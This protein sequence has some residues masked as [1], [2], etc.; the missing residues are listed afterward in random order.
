MSKGYV[1]EL[2][3]QAYEKWEP[4]DNVMILAGTGKGKSHFIK[5]VLNRH[6]RNTKK[7]VLL[8]TNRD[9]LKNQVRKD[10]GLN[11]IITVENY[12]KIESMILDDKA[13]RDYDYIV[14]DECHYFFTDSAF[15]I[16]TDIFFKWMLDNNE[17]CKI[18]MTATPFVL[19]QYF[20]LHGIEVKHKYELKTNYDYLSNI[21]MFDDYKTIDGIIESIPKDEQILFISRSAKRAYEVSKKFKGAFICSKHNGQFND[22]I[23]QEELDN[24]IKKSIFKSRLLCATTVL[25]NGIN[26]KEFSKVK[27]VI[28]D[29][30]D[31]DIFIQCLGRKRI[32]QGETVTLY[33]KNYNGKQVNGF[34]SKLVHGLKL[35]DILKELGEEEYVKKSFKNDM[36]YKYN[37]KI[38]DEIW[39]NDKD[40]GRKVINDCMY[41]KYQCDLGVC[42]SILNNPHKFSFKDL[43]LNELGIEKGR[44]IDMEVVTKVLS[45]EEMLESVTGERLHKEEQK[46]LVEFIGL[47]DARGRLQK[48]VGQLNEYLKAN[49]IQYVIIS[50]QIKINNKRTTVWIVEKL[51]E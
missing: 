38:I 50:K 18:F 28:I 46:E 44:I 1:E 30:F 47:K 22:F 21:Y 11:T 36:F 17:V 51:I 32:G 48:S 3:G 16:K 33:F 14:M 8:L 40:A 2:I 6:C 41:H 24:I 35:A 7:R 20:K 10:L 34:K 23:N 9:I 29:I 26:I 42:N 5:T 19:M 27:H 45:T 25:D 15:N 43:I 39:D 4:G 31:R 49:K 37:S 13:F 12:Q